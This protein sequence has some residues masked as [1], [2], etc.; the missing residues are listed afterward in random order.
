MRASLNAFLGRSA[1]RPLARPP[2]LPL[3][4]RDRP[5]PLLA[6]GLALQMLAVQS[7]QFIM[8]IAAAATITSDV[9]EVA[10]FLALSI[11]ASAWMQTLQ[12][13]RPDLDRRYLEI[14]V[15]KLV[16]R[17]ARKRKAAGG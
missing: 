6:L 15:K 16:A 5:A 12:A 11:L 9:E 4:F 14:F 8:P 3:A 1:D 2:D 13:L 10:R 17:L 7:V